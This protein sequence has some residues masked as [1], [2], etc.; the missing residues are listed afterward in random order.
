MV[1][2]SKGLIK[3]LPLISW[4]IFLALCF[5]AGAKFFSFLFSILDVSKSLRII[6]ATYEM[7]EIKA[8]GVGN[9]IILNML[10]IFIWVLK[11]VLFYYIIKIISKVNYITP[12]TANLL[13]N[14]SKIGNIALTI[15]VASFITTAFATWILGEQRVSA[16][17]TA[18][19]FGGG[20][21][22]ILTAAIVFAIAQVLK[23]GW[24][25]QSENEFTI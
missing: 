21:E 6:V 2:Q 22:Y 4:L 10:L 23:R 3:I 1:S 12:F 18:E 24:E 20:V 16:G 17:K 7:K 19:Y 13:K 11:A 5:K 8:F 9:Y 14:I 15:G 25:L